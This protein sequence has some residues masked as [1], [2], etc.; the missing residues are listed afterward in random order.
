MT[1]PISPTAP[2]APTVQT[3][4]ARAVS[5]SLLRVCQR[6]PFFATLALH[7]RI[8][9]TDTLPTAATDG[10]DVFVNPYFFN[11]LTRDAQD[12][13]ILHEVLHAALLHVPRRSTRDARMWNIACFPPGTWLGTGQPIECAAT[14]VRLFDGDLTVIHT[15]IGTLA[16]TPEHPILVRQRLGRE[17][18]SAP[19]HIA[20]ITLSPA[21]WREAGRMT[22][23]D[24]VLVPRQRACQTTDYIDLNPHQAGGLSELDQ[25]GHQATQN[26]AT[27]RL[28][29]KGD[30]AW[31]IGQFVASQSGV[32]DAHLRQIVQAGL[33]PNQTRPTPQAQDHDR[34]EQAGPVRH[35]AGVRARQQPSVALGT[36]P[37][38]APEVWFETA[39]RGWLIETAG[40]SPEARRIPRIILH[41]PDDHIRHAFLDGFVHGA[42]GGGDSVTS[43]GPG[44]H[45]KGCRVEVASQAL[46]I[47]LMTLI[48]QD[49]MGG[50]ITHDLQCT[51]WS[52]VAQTSD[53]VGYRVSWCLDE[54]AL[55]TRDWECTPWFADEDGVWYPVRQV[56]KRPYSGPVYNLST[57]S[58][59]YVANGVLVHNCDI[60]VNGMVTRAGF[61]LPEG[62]IRDTSKEHLS[63]EEVFELLLRDAE[64]QPTLEM[65]DLL[66]GMPGSDQAGDAQDKPSKAELEG[67]W[68]QA[69]QQAKMVMQTTMAGDMPADLKRE[70][71]PLLQS[72]IDW[73]SYLWR[74]VVQ[75]PTDFGAFDRRFIGDGL[76]LETISG[77]SVRVHVC[78]DTSGSVTDDA[79]T[80]LVSEVQAILGAYAHMRCDL[81]YADTELHG[82]YELTRD[83]VPPEP[84]GGGGTDFRPFFAWL[85]SK[86]DANAITVAI[87]LTD[88]YGDFPERAPSMPTL[89][90]VTPGGRDASDFPFGDVIRVL[91]NA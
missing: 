43:G 15:D 78:V 81:Y 63:T 19:G 32:I 51:P 22:T 47:D 28:P 83:S 71:G 40:A 45:S 27:R 90:V 10:R 13:L 61:T 66:D 56:G 74:Y 49:G 5:A 60:V 42:H 72:Q 6:S 48:A 76:Y 50:T 29:L 75:T 77:E 41:H 37:D 87:Y 26:Q 70:L 55:A 82:P 20:P 21:E 4:T 18:G 25:S 65:A 9:I 80:A 84:I 69:L 11:N 23:G 79:V 91:P 36:A 31:L 24:F 33:A 16:C 85:D 57:P 39:L 44:G 67:K 88:G 35:L 7:A 86:A 3:D 89:W 12:G 1:T 52:S 46:A 58:H 38:N 34:A 59:T 73:R 64:E 30:V 14:L 17:H 68:K 8:K 62:G 53:I 54:G 2:T